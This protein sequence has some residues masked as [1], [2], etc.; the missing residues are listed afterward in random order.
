MSSSRYL[1]NI[2]DLFVFLDLSL[3][4][5]GG[6]FDKGLVIR[7]AKAKIPVKTFLFTFTDNIYIKI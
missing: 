1:D 3:V 2:F 5:G 6:V 4:I 7:I